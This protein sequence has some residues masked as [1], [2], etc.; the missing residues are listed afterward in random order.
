MNTDRN[1]QN[2]PIRPYVKHFQLLW[3]IYVAKENS[4]YA[5]VIV[6]DVYT[7]HLCQ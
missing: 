7:C 5:N 4:N 2:I 3:A 6:M 1:V